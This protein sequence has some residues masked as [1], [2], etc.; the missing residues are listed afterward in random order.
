M[1]MTILGLVLGAMWVGERTI[2]RVTVVT[3]ITSTINAI[4]T[5]SE[6]EGGV[7]NE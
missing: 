6:G 2:A 7:R 1:I 3:T 4:N 5:W